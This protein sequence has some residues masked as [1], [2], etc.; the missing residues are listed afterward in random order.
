MISAVNIAGS[1]WEPGKRFRI[2]IRGG[3][4]GAWSVDNNV[5]PELRWLAS[6]DVKEGTSCMVP[7]RGMQLPLAVMIATALKRL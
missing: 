7:K 2:K 4:P 5:F 6:E 1:A 3:C